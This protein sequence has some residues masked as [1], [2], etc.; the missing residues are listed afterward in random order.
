MSS[1]YHQWT[2]DEVDTLVMEKYNFIWEVYKEVRFPTMR[3]DI[4][5]VAILHAYGGLYADLDMF[6]NRV[7]YE[8]KPFVISAQETRNPELGFVEEMELLIADRGNSIL[9]EWM[10][11]MMK[12]IQT[13]DYKSPKSPKILHIHTMTYVSNTTGSWALKQFIKGKEIEIEKQRFNR[14]NGKQHAKQLELDYLRIN[15]PDMVEGLTKG[16]LSVLD[17]IC[18]RSMSYFNMAFDVR[19]PVAQKRVPLLE[20]M[21]HPAHDKKRKRAAEIDDQVE[22]GDATLAPSQHTAG[23]GLSAPLDQPTAGTALPA[24]LPQAQGS[25]PTSVETLQAKFAAEHAKRLRAES[26]RDAWVH[27]FVLYWNTAAA[28]VMYQNLPEQLQTQV[29]D[30]RRW[31]RK[32]QELFE[33]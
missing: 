29:K 21:S 5:R 16:E 22:S 1:V 19:V 31:D 7:E 17:A 24:N 6:P 27:Q 26:E 9:L 20:L 10:R 15:R 4:G 25:Q 33:Q 3:A 11:H 30:A 18:Y 8:Q 12:Q 14:I 13:I 28:K 2:A 23:T 32:R